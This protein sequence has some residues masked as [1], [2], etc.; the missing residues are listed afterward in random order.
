MDLVRYNDC[1]VD[2]RN[3][4]RT[5]YLINDACIMAGR[6]PE[7]VAMKNGVSGRGGSPIL[8]VR[9]RATGTE[10]KFKVYKK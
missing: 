2:A 6:D 9:G 3:N 8:L 5:W 7:L 10:R 1:V 4:L